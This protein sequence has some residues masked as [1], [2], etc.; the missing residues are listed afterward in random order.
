MSDASRTNPPLAEIHFPLSGIKVTGVIVKMDT[1]VIGLRITAKPSVFS[2]IGEEEDGEVVFAVRGLLH[3]LQITYLSCQDGILLLG[4]GNILRGAQL[5]KAERVDVVVHVSWR[6]GRDDGSHGAWYSGFTEDISITGVK[7]L[8]PPP[9]EVPKQIEALIYLKNEVSSE[10][11]GALEKLNIS[12]HSNANEPPVK[13]RG[14][15]RHVAQLPDGNVTLG[16]L[17]SRISDVDK[18]RVQNFLISCKQAKYK[19]GKEACSA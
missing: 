7:L 19:M 2:L 8:I 1:H 5:R 3:R 17:F 14:S 4:I 13:I 12:R 10:A 9:Q 16:V 6:A 15:I 18:V 11:G